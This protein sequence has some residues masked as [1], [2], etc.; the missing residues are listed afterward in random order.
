MSGSELAALLGGEPPRKRRAAAVAAQKNW[1]MLSNPDDDDDLIVEQEII[2]NVPK[3]VSKVPQNSKIIVTNPVLKRTSFSNNFVVLGPDM[4]RNN[5]IKRTVVDRD[6][7]PT[8]DLMKQ[9]HGMKA[10]KTFTTP[11]PT[12]RPIVINKTQVIQPSPRQVI[13][14]KGPETVL[15]ESETSKR[16]ILRTDGS[17]YRKPPLIKLNPNEPLDVPTVEGDVEE[18][19]GTYDDLLEDDIPCD[20]FIEELSLIMFCESEN[21][22][23]NETI[24]KSKDSEDIE[25]IAEVGNSS[26]QNKTPFRAIQRTA[27]NRKLRP[28]N[29]HFDPI[30]DTLEMECENFDDEFTDGLQIDC[31]D[32][33]LSETQWKQSLEKR[34]DFMEYSKSVQSTKNVKF[35]PEDQVKEEIGK[36]TKTLSETTKVVTIPPVMTRSSRVRLSTPVQSIR[37][38]IPSLVNQSTPLRPQRVTT[39]AMPRLPTLNQMPITII[40]VSSGPGVTNPLIISP[41]TFVNTTAF[42]SNVPYILQSG[43]VGQPT[44]VM[45]PRSSVTNAI[46][47]QNLIISNGSPVYRSNVINTTT[48]QSIQLSNVIQRPPPPRTIPSNYIRLPPSSSFTSPSVSSPPVVRIRG[49]NNAIQLQTYSSIQQ[50]KS[51]T[52]LNTSQTNSMFDCLTI[53]KGTPDA[54]KKITTASV[55]TIKPLPFSW[56]SNI[57]ELINSLIKLGINCF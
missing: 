32:D 8:L 29:G 38:P 50:Q 7:S 56:P 24:N 6:Y 27:V 28:L 21:K 16:Y 41:Q 25:I 23:S 35:L 34:K 37:A 17:V 48:P 33:I 20:D 46:S 14:P 54:S 5:N 15:I 18:I 45:V 3:V 44:Y 51:A 40:P 43:S 13:R 57:D 53:F 39:T 11:S 52:N 47:A 31:E 30:I 42:G 55:L 36:V 49:T 12:F 19:I 9:S 2:R 1:Q 22:K 26:T 4:T 10:K